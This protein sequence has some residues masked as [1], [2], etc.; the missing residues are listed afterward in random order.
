MPAPNPFEED[1][2]EGEETLRESAGDSS[3]IGLS[4]LDETG[5]TGGSPADVAETAGGSHAVS[6]EPQ[7]R[8]LPRSLSVPAV[9]SA[10]DQSAFLPTDSSEANECDHVTSCESKV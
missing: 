2:D 5:N 10:H 8:I 4:A 6:D 7:S 9:T 3:Q 1:V